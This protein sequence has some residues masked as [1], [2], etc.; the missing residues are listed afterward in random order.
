MSNREGHDHLS[1]VDDGAG[2]TEIWETLSERRERQAE[3][4]G[5]NIETGGNAK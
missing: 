4:R 1:D 3:S 2:C 5:R